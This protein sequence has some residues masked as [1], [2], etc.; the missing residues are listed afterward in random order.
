[1]DIPGATRRSTDVT[2]LD[3]RTLSVR[4]RR[5]DSLREDVGDWGA[6]VRLPH[7]VDGDD[8]QATVADGVL[9]VKL[10]RLD[11]GRRRIPVSA[12]Q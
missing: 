5:M 7:A 6:L 8:V 9:T 12:S 10:P 3:E 4:A 1:M 11:G 2:L